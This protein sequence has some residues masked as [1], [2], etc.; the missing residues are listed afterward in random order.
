MAAK[1]Q[2]VAGTAMGPGTVTSFATPVMDRDGQVFTDKGVAAGWW[3]IEWPQK[4]SPKSLSQA[5]GQI[6]GTVRGAL[7]ACNLVLTTRNGGYILQLQV[8]GLET[9]INLGEEIANLVVACQN[10]PHGQD[11]WQADLTKRLQTAMAEANN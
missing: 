8:E 7:P 9:E 6:E 2:S 4:I 3:Y 1:A 11:L 10:S 5:V